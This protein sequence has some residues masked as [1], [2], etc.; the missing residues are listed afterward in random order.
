MLALPLLAAVMIVWHECAHTV[1]AWLAGDPSARFVLVLDTPRQQCVGCNLYDSAALDPARNAV[2]NLAGVLGTQLL[3]WGSLLLLARR[4]R[5][6]VVEVLLSDLLALTVVGDL[7]FQTVQGFGSRI[8]ASEP[9]GR[10]TSYVDATAVV[11]FTAQATGVSVA[12]VA[13][14]ATAV[15]VLDLLVL[16]AVLVRLVRRRTSAARS[17][18]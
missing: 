16:G 1:A 9:L 18:A 14:V 10:S 13:A 11:S 6:A 15:V 8:P 5:V 3:A 4:R 7:V 12:V 2:V 17:A